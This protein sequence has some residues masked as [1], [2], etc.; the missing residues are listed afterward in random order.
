[1][2]KKLSKYQGDT[3][4]SQVGP[5]TPMSKIKSKTVIKSGNGN[6]KTVEK[7]TSSPSGYSDSSKTRRTIKGIVT[8]APKPGQSPRTAPLIDGPAPTPPMKKQL[9]AKKGG[10]IKKKK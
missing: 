7:R 10:A 3:G 8:G 4:G 2:K 9:M 5:V 6:Y 1:M